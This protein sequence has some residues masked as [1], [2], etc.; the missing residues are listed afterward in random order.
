MNFAY[1]AVKK[2]DL[3]WKN[4]PAGSG[5]LDTKAFLDHGYVPQK[6]ATNGELIIDSAGSSLSVSHTLEYSFSAFATAQMAN[7]LGKTAD[8]KKMLKYSNGWQHVFNPLNKL[9][10]PKKADGKFIEKFDP[11]AS[12][13]GYQEGN[14]I[15]YTFYVP[16]NPGA[17]IKAIGK[18]YFNKNL[19]EIFEKSEKDG[20]GGGKTINAFAGISSIYNHGNQPSLHISWLFNFSG[21][22]WLTQKWTRSICEV[23]Y[24]A[25]PIHVYGYGQDEDEGQLGS[26]Y[27]ITSLGLF[28][29]KGFTDAKPIM[30]LSSPVFDKATIILGNQKKLIIE[31]R[32]N[33]KQNVYIQSAVFNGKKL[34]NCWLY[35]DE[36]MQGGKLLFTMGSKPNKAWGSKVPP[37][38]K[39]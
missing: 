8:Y 5:K 26:W 23:F 22:P 11:M 31:A 27:V 34:N 37:P 2:N 15:Q 10:Q 3:G 17:L 25:E 36:L 16:Q 6:D 39:Q 9:V 7:A 35:R 13:R 4:R 28:D 19:N 38:S 14:A 32:N 29:V 21:N 18:D 24:G 12:W 30:E 1:E 33:S 20:F